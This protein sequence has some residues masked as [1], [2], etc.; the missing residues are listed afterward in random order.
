[1][2]GRASLVVLGRMKWLAWGYEEWS[3][4]LLCGSFHWGSVLRRGP[5]KK[6]TLGIW[7]VEAEARGKRGSQAVISLSF[8]SPARLWC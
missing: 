4:G 2:G 3:L 7:E 1:M 6:V 8:F 5:V